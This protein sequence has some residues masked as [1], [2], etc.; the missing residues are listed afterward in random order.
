LYAALSSGAA[1]WADAR[2]PELLAWLRAGQRRSEL[3]ELLRSGVSALPTLTAAHARALLELLWDW[4]MVDAG[5][6]VSAL[7]Q[8]RA[9]ADV[10]ALRARLA[11]HTRDYRAAIEA[12]EVAIRALLQPGL[13]I[14]EF[15][16]LCVAGAPAEGMLR[17]E[18]QVIGSR[19]H[20]SERLALRW[21]ALHRAGMSRDAS[22]M[23]LMCQRYFPERASVWA[24]AGNHALDAAELNTAEAYFQ[25]CLQLDPLWTAGLA[26]LAIVCERRKDWAAALPYRRRVV[27][28][29]QALERDDAASLQRRLRYAAAL[30]RLG[31]WR[32]AEPLFRAAVRSKALAQLPAEH[33]V[34][35][36]VFSQDL[37]APA[38]VAALSG[39]ADHTSTA[40]SANDPAQAAPANSEEPASGSAQSARGGS[41]GAAIVLARHEAVLL[42]QLALALRELAGDLSEQRWSLA[43]CAFLAGELE[44]AFELLDQVE[45]DR[46]DDLTLHYL[47]WR[48]ASASAH[49][50]TASIRAFAEQAARAAWARGA[51]A[52]EQERGYAL[53]ILPELSDASPPQHSAAELHAQEEG[54]VLA[55]LERIVAFRAWREAE[56]GSPLVAA[57][58]SSLV[59]AAL[60]A[61]FTSK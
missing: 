29:E 19:V 12:S 37:Y 1:D 42:E 10:A 9:D 18:R 3:Q 48:C 13:S 38:L 61:S 57:A 22:L 30:A 51:A 21:E 4:S 50:Q 43:L 25:R 52:S 26:G 39:G 20:L 28:V 59:L 7:P 36:R 14:E 33:P 60:V 8:L 6:V 2:V 31:R 27:E 55:E 56:G 47:L 49:P 46:P 5:R 16:R 58:A 40:G 44:R 45:V 34:L 35:V 11:M 15:L 32:D 24:T 54:P 41:E 17:F 53:A 23:Q